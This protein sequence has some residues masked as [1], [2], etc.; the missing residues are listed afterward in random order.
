MTDQERAE[1][2]ISKEE[3][4]KCRDCLW[5]GDANDLEYSEECLDGE[6]PRCGSDQVYDDCGITPEEADND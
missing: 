3:P 6:C 2:I 1:Q 5:V 4:L